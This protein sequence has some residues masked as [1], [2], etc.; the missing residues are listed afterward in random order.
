L[1]N[2]H[3]FFCNKFHCQR[4]TS[5][6]GELGRWHFCTT[7]L[8]EAQALYRAFADIYIL[9]FPVDA[10]TTSRRINTSNNLLFHDYPPFGPQDPPFSNDQPYVGPP[11]QSHIDF[12]LEESITIDRHITLLGYFRRLPPTDRILLMQN[13][14]LQ[15]SRL[16]ATALNNTHIPRRSVEISKAVVVA[17]LRQAAD[18]FDAFLHNLQ[19]EYIKLVDAKTPLRLRML[20]LRVPFGCML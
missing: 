14:M 15:S 20:A 16:R 19:P 10:D 11:P 7:H 5:H 17:G 3:T 1:E 2:I 8:A 13:A 4:T 6:Q 18:A 12:W 9:L